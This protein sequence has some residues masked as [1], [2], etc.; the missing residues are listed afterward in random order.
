MKTAE[1]FVVQFHMEIYTFNFIFIVQSG[2]KVA[3]FVTH[4]EFL[5]DVY[6]FIN[7]PFS[8]I[9]R[10]HDKVD[11]FGLQNIFNQRHCGNTMWNLQVPILEQS[12]PDEL[13]ER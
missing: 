6:V 12:C 7:L 9:S 8:C 4:K 1:V 2:D 13:N 3:I 5:Q 10:F 11:I